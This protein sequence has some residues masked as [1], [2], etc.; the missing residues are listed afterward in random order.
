M[1]DRF[2]LLKFTPKISVIDYYTYLIFKYK[3]SIFS[4]KI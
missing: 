3:I 2:I 1:Y 4:K